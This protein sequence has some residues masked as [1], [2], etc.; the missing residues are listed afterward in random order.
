MGDHPKAM[1]LLFHDWLWFALFFLFSY[2]R[3][4]MVLFQSLRFRLVRWLRAEARWESCAAFM[5]GLFLRFVLH[6]INANDGNSFDM[7]L[8]L[9]DLGT[10]AMFTTG[11]WL[12]RFQTLPGSILANYSSATSATFR[13]ISRCWKL[14]R[15]DTQSFIYCLYWHKYCIASFSFR[16]FFAELRNCIKFVLWRDL[17]ACRHHSLETCGRQTGLAAESFF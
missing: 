5:S 10:T 3:Y 11:C 8:F 14:N 9:I 1:I 7:A 15:F 6:D 13:L 17:L 16:S 2:F 12:G 4:C